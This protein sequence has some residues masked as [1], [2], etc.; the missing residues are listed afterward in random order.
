MPDFGATN[1]PAT[2]PKAA[3]RAT[4]KKNLFFFIL[5]SYL[6]TSIID[7]FAKNYF[8]LVLFMDCDLFCVDFVFFIDSCFRLEESSSSNS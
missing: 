5:N 4:P 6:V 8:F 7:D 2:T 1:R 3:P